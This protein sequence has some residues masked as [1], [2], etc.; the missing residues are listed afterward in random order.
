MTPPNVP[1]SCGCKVIVP[2]GVNFERHIVFCPLHA[3]AREMLEALKL[4]VGFCV[5]F[6]EDNKCWNEHQDVGVLYSKLSPLLERI[7]RAEKGQPK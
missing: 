5:A 4:S 6:R 1:P 3:S 2:R 7:S